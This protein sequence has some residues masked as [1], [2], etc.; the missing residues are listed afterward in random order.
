MNQYFTCALQVQVQRPSLSACV[1]TPSTL[2]YGLNCS[3]ASSKVT[4]CNNQTWNP[5]V[6]SEPPRTI[7]P[8]VPTEMTCIALAPKGGRENVWMDLWRGEGV[9]SNPGL[10]QMTR[11]WHAAGSCGLLQLSVERFKSCLLV[12][13][14]HINRPGYK[15]Y[16]FHESK[17]EII[18][19]CVVKFCKN[20]VYVIPWGKDSKASSLI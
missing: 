17:G 12:L 9:R 5:S 20:T 14:R 7:P 4:A 3:R 18:L 10:F 15:Y 13:R 16:S 11:S 19:C 8:M 6:T 1:S 2:F